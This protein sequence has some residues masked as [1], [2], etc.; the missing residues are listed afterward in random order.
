[1]PAVKPEAKPEWAV[2]GTAVFVEPPAGDKLIGWTGAKPP[3]QWFNWLHRFYSFWI[4]YFEDKTDEL[5]TELREVYTAVVG[6]SELAT[7]ETLAEALAAVD[8]GSKILV[9][10]QLELSETVDVDK[11]DIHIKFQPGAGLTNNGAGTGLEISAARCTIEGGRMLGFTGGGDIAISFIENGDYG[12]VLFTRF[13]AGT[14]TE[15]AEAGVAAGRFP[16]I[17]GTM[18]EV[19]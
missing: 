11:A 14:E 18:T 4:D 5:Q 8:P 9:L 3:Y 1:M 7:H 13:A 16:V 2:G 10:D 15:V 12:Q 19:A 6:G 17:L